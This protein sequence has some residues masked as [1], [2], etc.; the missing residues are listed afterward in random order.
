MDRF[1]KLLSLI[2]CPIWSTITPEELAEVF[3][4]TNDASYDLAIETNRQSAWLDR[5]FRFSRGKAREW[6]GEALLGN[7]VLDHFDLDHL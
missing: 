6:A 7:T 2:D 1:D 3:N 4:E 5:I